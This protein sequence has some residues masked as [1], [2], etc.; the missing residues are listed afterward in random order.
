MMNKCIGRRVGNWYG[1]FLLFEKY[2]NFCAGSSMI[3]PEQGASDY[4]VM[5]L[6]LRFYLNKGI[7]H[8]TPRNSPGTGGICSGGL[9]SGRSLLTKVVKEVD[10]TWDQIRKAQVEI[11]TE[12]GTVKIKK[13]TFDLK[14]EITCGSDGLHA[15]VSV[16]L[17]F[18]R[19]QEEFCI[20]WSE[21]ME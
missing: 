2:F 21:L 8:K 6:Q 17:L 12:E 14:Q 1:W 13:S 15:V 3:W 7:S 20:V 18:W 9:R 11:Q 10:S 16:S 19:V 5:R 4:L